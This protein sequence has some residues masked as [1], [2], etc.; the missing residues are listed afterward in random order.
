MSRIANAPVE[1]P[2]G[3]EVSLSASEISIKGSKGNLSLPIHELVEIKQEENSLKFGAVN[4]TKKIARAI[5]HF[6]RIG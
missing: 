2:S 4:T 1:I 5:R 6:P 3:V